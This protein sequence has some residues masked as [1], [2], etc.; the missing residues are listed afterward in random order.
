MLVDSRTKEAK[1]YMQT[2]ATETAAMTR[3]KVKFRKRIIKQP[4]LLCTIFLES[5]HMY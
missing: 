2:G 5:L 4:S 1:L 3:Q